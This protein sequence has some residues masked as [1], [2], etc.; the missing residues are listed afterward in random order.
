QNLENRLSEH[1]SGESK[2]TRY[3][4]PWSLVYQENFQTRSEAVRREMYFK[5]V[6]G[7]IELKRL[8]IL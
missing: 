1:N 4:A 6:E 8:G 3:K 5:T 7:R 2:A